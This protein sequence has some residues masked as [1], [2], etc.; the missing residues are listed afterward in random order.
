MRNRRDDWS[1]ATRVR[2]THTDVGRT[3]PWVPFA[4]F[5]R[6]VRM[7]T[8]GSTRG[9]WG[10]L[11]RSISEDSRALRLGVARFAGIDV[12]RTEDIDQPLSQLEAAS[13]SLRGRTNR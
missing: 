6:P 10:T 1:P 3:H 12:A 5:H 7:V 2:A 11:R 4:S 13:G 8:T 9:K